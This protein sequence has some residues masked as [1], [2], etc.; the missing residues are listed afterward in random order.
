[1]CGKGAGQKST[2]KLF[3][4]IGQVEIV[5]SVIP[6]VFFSS[7]ELSLYIELDSLKNTLMGGISGGKTGKY[8][9]ADNGVVGCCN[10]CK[11]CGGK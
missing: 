5:C 9:K 11:C 1:M 7:G 10:S 3:N 6:T 8:D 4:R 2:Y